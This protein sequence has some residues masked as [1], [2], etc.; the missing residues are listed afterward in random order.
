MQPAHHADHAVDSRHATLELLEGL[1][2][3]VHRGGEVSLYRCALAAVQARAGAITDARRTLDALAADGYPFR[4]AT[5]ALAMAELAEAA[6]VAG[7]AE[8]AAHVLAEMAPYSGHIAAT[9]T[10]INRPLDQALAQA[11]LATGDTTLAEEYAASAVSASRH[12][13]T[14]VFLCRELVFLAAARRRAGRRTRRSNTGRRG[15]HLAE[16]VGALVVLADLER[17]GLSR[18]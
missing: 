17:Y 1:E 13:N 9:A 2:R 16:D 10:G 12:R 15:S 3:I 14:P 8:T 5:V 6:E 7:H 4:G 11:A 18:T